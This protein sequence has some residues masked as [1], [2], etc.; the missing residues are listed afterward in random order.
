M[1]DRGAAR[2][3]ASRTTRRPSGSSARRPARSGP[4]STRTRRTRSRTSERPG[5]RSGARPTGGSP[6]SSPASAPAARSPASAATSRRR[7]PTCRSSAPT[8]T[9]SVYSG[10][11]R[12]AVP[13]RGRRRGLLA[14][15]RSTRRS[16]TA[17]SR[18]A[19]P[20]A[21][22]TARR[23]TREEGL[24]IGGSGGTA[25][26]PRSRS[27]SELG[28]DDVVVVLAPRLRPR[29]PVEDLR[30]RVDGRLRLPA[31]RATA[32]SPTCSTREGESLPPLVLRQPERHRARRDRADARARRLAAAA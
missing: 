26:P 15:P 16:S 1:P 13:R 29:L 9:G 7:T 14:R 23:V 24:L 22:L 27:R 17:S 31:H 20:T 28:P 19:T 5:P 18:S 30:R 11:I 4:T 21:F 6:T 25:V 8:P 10:G 32:A 3:S 12:P 2:G